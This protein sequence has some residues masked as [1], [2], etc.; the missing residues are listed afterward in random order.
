[1]NLGVLT[2]TCHP[3]VGHKP[4][5]EGP[6]TFEHSFPAQKLPVGPGHLFIWFAHW[7]AWLFCF[8]SL[9]NFW[10]QL[11][12]KLPSGIGLLYSK[13]PFLANQKC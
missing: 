7:V 1:M 11:Y 5:S 4:L 6:S 12:A 10:C 2:A 9:S 3:L 8:V 13:I